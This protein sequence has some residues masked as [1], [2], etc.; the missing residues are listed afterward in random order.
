MDLGQVEARPGFAGTLLQGPGDDLDGHWLGGVGRDGDK[1][2]LSGG[3][4]DQSEG[5]APKEGD[6]HA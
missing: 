6:R 5:Q 1:D 3:R 2:R 4:A